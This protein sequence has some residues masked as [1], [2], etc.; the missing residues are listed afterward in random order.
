VEDG[1]TVKSVKVTDLIFCMD[2]SN[3][4]VERVLRILI[5]GGF[6]ASPVIRLANQHSSIF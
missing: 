5:A 2:G 6:M 3:K 4:N 1:M